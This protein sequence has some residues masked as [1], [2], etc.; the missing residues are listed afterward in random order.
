MTPLRTTALAILLLGASSV[1]AHAEFA[2][3]LGYEKIVRG[4]AALERGD[5]DRAVTLT[6]T[7]VRQARSKF[8]R[9]AGHNNLCVAY[10]R[11][12][13]MGQ[14]VAACQAS[15]DADPRFWQAYV[16][17]GN[18]YYATGDAAQAYDAYQK[19]AQ[20]R[21]E[22]RKVRANLRRVGRTIAGDISAVR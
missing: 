16:N 3:L 14:A 8:L 19:A 4:A 12:G 13:E 2:S 21:P 22:D 5:V 20:I 15:L 1:P 11:M 18:A 10:T 6:E 7:G 9:A 17:L